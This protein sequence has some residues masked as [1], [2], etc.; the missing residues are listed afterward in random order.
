M[1]EAGKQENPR[2]DVWLR[3]WFYRK[4]LDST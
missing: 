1:K 3:V 4:T 2:S